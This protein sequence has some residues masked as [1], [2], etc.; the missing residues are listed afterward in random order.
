MVL[1][2][3]KITECATE[4]ERRSGTHY[5]I[6]TKDETNYDIRLTHMAV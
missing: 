3:M 6:V 4:Q 2:K 1:K 5:R